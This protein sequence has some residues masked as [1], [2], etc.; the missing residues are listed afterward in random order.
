M[1]TD[2]LAYSKKTSNV[3]LSIGSPTVL[4]QRSELVIENGVVIDDSEAVLE[5]ISKLS[6][7]NISSAETFKKF[8]TNEKATKFYIDNKC[9]CKM[10]PDRDTVYLWLDSGFVDYYGNPIMISLLNS[11]GEYRGHYFGSFQTLSNAIRGFFPRNIKDINRNLG[12]LRNK[13]E[14]KIADR[15]IKHIED[16]NEFFLSLCNK[17]ESLGTMSFVLENMQVLRKLDGMTDKE[18]AENSLEAVEE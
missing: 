13:Y 5:G 10:Q 8:I 16:E 7:K 9:A 3:I 2:A 6:G 12:G 14:C 1:T 15:K 4:K 18:F 11:Y 17:D